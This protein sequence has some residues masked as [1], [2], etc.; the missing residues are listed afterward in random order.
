MLKKST[1]PRLARMLCLLPC[2]LLPAWG[3]AQGWAVSTIVS[4]GLNY[5]FGVAVDSADNVFVADTFNGA[6]HKYAPDGSGG[7][8][9]QGD[10][11]NGLSYP[12]GVAA[13]GAGNVFVADTNNNAI[14]KYA[15]NGSGGYTQQNVVAVGLNRPGD[16]A[17][18]SAGNVFVAD[19]NNNAI[20]KYAPN[21]SGGYTQQ[22][23]V[24]VGLNRPYGVA[25]D[26]VGNVFVADANNNAIRKYAPDGSGG[27][28]Q[29]SDVANTGLSLPYGVA[30]DSA[31]NVFVADRNN[32]AIRK[33]APNGSGGYTQQSDVANGLASSAGVAVD[34][35]GNVYIA[36]TYGHRILRAVAHANVALASSGSSPALAGQNIAFTATVTPGNTST[37]TGTVTF[38]NGATEL[39]TAP[40]TSGQATLATSALAGGT[41]S[42][43]ARY[44]GDAD[45][46]SATSTPL[47]QAVHYAITPSTSTASPAGASSFTCTAASV[48]PGGGAACTATPATGY[49]L[50]ALAGCDSTDLATGHCA[51]SNVQANQAPVA[52][53]G[54][55]LQG[56][57]VPATGTGGPASATVS[58]G[59]AH[60]AFDPAATGFAAAGATPQGK[61]APQGAFRL[62]LTGCTPGA[63]VRVTTVWPQPVADFTKH[64]QGAFLPVGHFAI[65]GNTVGFDVTDGG[66]GDDDGVADGV[67]VDPAMPL[68]AAAPG[69]VR[70]VPT[71]GPWSAVLLSALAALSALRGL[72]RVQAK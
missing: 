36:D 71:L 21:G 15:P 33:Y 9:Q 66:V 27:Y 29:Q 8:T 53:F 44:D 59:G 26:S 35:A 17:V 25:V 2:L 13:D 10:V 60:C 11:A 43:T 37:P 51:F 68:A 45:N 50:L 54:L 58:G 61:V 46:A 28:T 64:S 32:N 19:T 5:P 62:R 16:V 1:L 7:Y 70:P 56:T 30:V 24:T 14:R 4:T 34:G 69:G 31:G 49:A 48:A 38:L 42:I 12:G 3:W 18:D 20:H 63:T 23:V 6:I 65:S 72:R 57:T 52:R 40:L 22:N 55:Q 39:G 67:I 41:H 47:A